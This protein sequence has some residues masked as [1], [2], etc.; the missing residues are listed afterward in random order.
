MWKPYLAL[1]VH[2]G[3]ASFLLYF[4]SSLDNHLGLHGRMRSWARYSFLIWTH[5]NVSVCGFGK[6]AYR[7]SVFNF[8]SSME[9]SKKQN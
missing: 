5:V 2:K 1:G 3:K 4:C 6:A 9:N 7:K 8:C